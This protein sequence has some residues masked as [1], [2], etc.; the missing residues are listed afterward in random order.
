MEAF[1]GFFSLL[2]VLCCILVPVV[3]VISLLL[4]AVLIAVG[5]MIPM[6][7]AFG[8]GFL[9]KEIYAEKTRTPPRRAFVE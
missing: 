5:A 4:I 2:V 9:I 8:V 1:G 6:Y 7:L 3:L